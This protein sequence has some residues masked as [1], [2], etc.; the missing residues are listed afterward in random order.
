MPLMPVLR[1]KSRWVSVSSKTARAREREKKERKL[2]V[3]SRSLK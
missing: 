3:V 2:N 1:R